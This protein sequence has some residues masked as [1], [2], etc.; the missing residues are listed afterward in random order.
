MAL[1]MKILALAAFMVGLGRPILV[2]SMA[3]ESNA[4]PEFPTKCPMVMA[5]AEETCV[6]AKSTCWSAGQKDVDCLEEEL[7]CFDGC[8]H[9]CK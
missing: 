2:A 5:K 8:A 7:C 1:S 4:L 9:H 6:D 3:I